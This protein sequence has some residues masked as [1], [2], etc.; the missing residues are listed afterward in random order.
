MGPALTFA[1]R[2]ALF[3]LEKMEREILATDRRRADGG[4]GGGEPSRLRE[5]LDAA[6][7]ADPTHWRDYYRGDEDRL[8]HARA[9]SLSDRCRYYWPR[10]EVRGARDRLLRNLAARPIPLSLLSEHLPTQYD[11]V[12][13]GELQP[14]P[15]AL[16][17]HRIGTVL[18]RYWSACGA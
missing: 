4:A 9:F 5:T 17:R 8:A 6:M 3:A 1:C 11:A 7:R 15:E 18:A 14:S 12:R 16:V 10:P 2:E 13:A